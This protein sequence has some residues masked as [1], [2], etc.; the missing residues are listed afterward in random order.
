MASEDEAV[1]LWDDVN[2]AMDSFFA[3]TAM[4]LGPDPRALE[5]LEAGSRLAEWWHKIHERWELWRFDR[6]IASAARHSPS[7]EEAEA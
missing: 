4:V 3:Q 1:G 6:R 2:S 5:P 7:S